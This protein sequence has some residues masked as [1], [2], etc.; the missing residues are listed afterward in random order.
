MSQDEPNKSSGL[1]SLIVGA[2]IGSVI[3]AGLA[4]DKGEKTRSKL[5]KGL[6]KLIK[7]L[8]KE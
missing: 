7:S 4:P 1:L 6:S 5:K 8:T 2:A 3:G